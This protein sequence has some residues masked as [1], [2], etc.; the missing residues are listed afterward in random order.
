LALKTIARQFIK[1]FV[2]LV[3]AVEP[4]E[5]LAKEIQ[6]SVKSRLAAHEYPRLIEFIDELPMTTTGKV[7]TVAL[8]EREKT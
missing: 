7:R 4:S 3:A 5:A 1:A 8:R 6:Q 2:V